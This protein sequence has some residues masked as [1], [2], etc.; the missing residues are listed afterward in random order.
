MLVL[1]LGERVRSIW[2]T[3]RVAVGT[4]SWTADIVLKAPLALALGL[5]LDAKAVE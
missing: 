2:L 3:N 1:N 5:H 4:S